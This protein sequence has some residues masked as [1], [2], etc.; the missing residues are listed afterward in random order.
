MINSGGRVRSNPSLSVGASDRIG[1]SPANTTR[2][3]RTP[4]P[5][6]RFRSRSA[7]AEVPA[8]A[9]S[10]VKNTPGR[11]RPAI[12]VG[13]SPEPV[14]SPYSTAGTPPE[15]MAPTTAPTNNGVI[16]D[17]PPEVAPNNRVSEDVAPDLLHAQ[18]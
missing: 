15:A 14:G 13:L 11:Q 1:Y 3:A 10:A 4:T 5:R 2:S 16:G 8:L 18:P 17:E 12:D 6:V 7:S 9:A